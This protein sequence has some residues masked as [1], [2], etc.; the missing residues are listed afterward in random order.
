MPNVSVI[1]PT[2]NRC[3]LIASSLDSLLNQSYPI[4]EILVV[5]D[6]STDDTEAVVAAFGDKVRYIRRENGGKNA[7]INTG[8]RHV[9]GE[10]IW[11]MDDDD[12]APADALERLV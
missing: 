11:I 10:L 12:L 4:A 6:G 8:L 9:T 2:F 5:D 7:A 3:G 1:L